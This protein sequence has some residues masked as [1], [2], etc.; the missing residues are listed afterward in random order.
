LGREVEGSDRVV[1]D[2]DRIDAIDVIDA[3]VFHRCYCCGGWRTSWQT[4]L[5]SGD[6]LAVVGGEVAVVLQ[7]SC[8]VAGGSLHF[9]GRRCAVVQFEMSSNDSFD[10]CGRG[11][12]SRDEVVVYI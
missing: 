4:L 7:L 11:R 10:S 5:E 2:D 12:T 1:D 3:V 9:I 6:L 8:L